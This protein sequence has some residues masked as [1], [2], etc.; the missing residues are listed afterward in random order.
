MDVT[1]EVSETLALIP[2][3]VAKMIAFVGHDGQEYLL[4]SATVSGCILRLD[5]RSGAFTAVASGL[6]QPTDLALD[7][8][9]GDLLVAEETEVSSIPL[10][11]LNVG[12]AGSRCPTDQASAGMTEY[13]IAVP[14]NTLGQW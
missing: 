2:E 4:M 5:P 12:L 10:V 9:S 11:S 14:H 1:E 8:I 6:N 3:E 7:A 13:W